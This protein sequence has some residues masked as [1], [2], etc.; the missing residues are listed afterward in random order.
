MDEKSKKAAVLFFIGSLLI[1]GF[2][3]IT[4]PVF[5]RLLTIE[6]YGIVVNYISWSGIVSC[7]IGLGLA[8]SVGNAWID[9]RDDVNSYIKI[10][11]IPIIVS[12]LILVLFVLFNENFICEIVGLTVGLSNLLIFYSLFFSI[13]TIFLLL[14]R[15]KLKANLILVL[16]LFDCIFGFIVSIGLI[17]MDVLSASTARIIGVSCPCFFTSIILLLSF[18]SKKNI[19]FSVAKTYVKYGLK[20]GIPMIPHGLA[21]IVLA[22]IDRVMI[23]NYCGN[24]DLGIYNMGYT[25]GA[26]IMVLI[27]AINASLTPWQY[28]A[29]NG[30]KYLDLKKTQLEISL[31]ITVVAV[32][33]ICFAP[34]ALVILGGEKYHNSISTVYPILIGTLF[35]YYYQYYCTTEAFYKKNIYIS[36]C[37]VGIGILNFVLNYFFIA[38][39]GYLAAAYTTLICYVVLYI[40]HM[41]LTK[42]VLGFELF[43]W[44]YNLILIASLCLL[45]FFVVLFAMNLMLRLTIIILFSCIYLK[46]EKNYILQYINKLKY[47]FKY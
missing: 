27:S 11:I 30:K 41:F 28:E 32:Y 17:Y 39:Y 36:I 44:K 15:Y 13:E 19:S 38:K 25:Y 40:V 47:R 3:I 4:T 37:S 10:I 23:N 24:Y 2:S 29:L 20:I 9:Y 34:E 6:E 26:M 1:K 12:S 46:Y 18:K 31:L 8:Y 42:K 5:A 16:S 43:H 35:Q 22:Q 33:F 7:C 45:S 14:L 21:M